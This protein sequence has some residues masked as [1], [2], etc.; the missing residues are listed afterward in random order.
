M[1]FLYQYMCVYTVRHH[2]GLLSSPVWLLSAEHCRV[3]I[4]NSA[5]MSFS[6]LLDLSF[7]PEQSTS[8]RPSAAFPTLH[9]P[10]INTV[11][12]P[13]VL[14]AGLLTC[15]QIIPSTLIRTPLRCPTQADLDRA[16]TQRTSG[17]L[18]SN[19][20]RLRKHK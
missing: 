18:G 13:S 19:R 7:P 17:L 16:G 4:Q 3:Q 9:N 14:T 5:L 11:M 10:D 8:H 12:F 2:N 6:S 20:R 1:T 15:F